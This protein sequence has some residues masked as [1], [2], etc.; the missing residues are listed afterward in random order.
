MHSFF[1]LETEKAVLAKEQRKKKKDAFV[2]Q[3]VL[4]AENASPF[5]LFTSQ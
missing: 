1:V 5:I 3:I 4:P 2:R